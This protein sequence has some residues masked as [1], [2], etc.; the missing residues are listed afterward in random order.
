MSI[1]ESSTSQRKHDAPAPPPTTFQ[2]QPAPGCGARTRPAGVMEQGAA[3]PEEAHTV[4]VTPSPLAFFHADGTILVT[5]S[6]EP[7]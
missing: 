5:A 4:Q 3:A 2:P 7:G 6:N 1:S